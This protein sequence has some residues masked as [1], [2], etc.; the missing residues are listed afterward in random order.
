MSKSYNMGKA[1]QGEG[2]GKGKVGGKGYAKSSPISP[3]DV[4]GKGYSPYGGSQTP[5]SGNNNYYW[6]WQG[7]YWWWPE[8]ASG[9]QNWGHMGREWPEVAVAE[10]DYW[11]RQPE[12][13]S[14][15]QHGPAS[16]GGSQTP[17]KKYIEKIDNSKKLYNLTQN[18]F[19][20]IFSV[21]KGQRRKQRLS[22]ENIR[23]DSAMKRSDAKFQF[24]PLEEVHLTWPF[25][26][27]QMSEIM[28]IP[29]WY[30]EHVEKR[31]KELNSLVK[32]RS[33]KWMAEVKHGHLH[34]T[35][36]GPF[37]FVLMRFMYASLR[38]A[39]PTCMEN[40]EIENVGGDL[41]SDPTRTSGEVKHLLNASQTAF[42]KSDRDAPPWLQKL[43][44]YV[45]GV[46]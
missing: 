13:A 4:G 29:R 9:S 21:E 5:P 10:P 18:A 32:I 22:I 1:S 7:Q 23:K 14:G 39:Y 38:S 15:S 40:V 26:I 19:T 44:G 36:C 28:G 24:D 41:C 30:Q 31:A 3:F 27:N 33:Q 12:T 25:G 45:S 2:K 37:R 6:R 8:E 35:L 42:T 17:P 11:Q 46:E 16:Y 20:D 43:S 34:A